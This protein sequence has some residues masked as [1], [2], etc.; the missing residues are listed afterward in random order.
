MNPSHVPAPPLR[1]RWITCA[2]PD[3]TARLRL[4]C[5]PFAGGGAAIWHP[6]AV[7]LAGTAEIVAFRLPGRESRFNEPPYTDSNT[8]VAALVDELAPFTSQPF[9]LCGHSLG[10]LLSFEVARALRRCGLSLPI[11]LIVSGVKAAH[12]PR[13]WPDIH[14]LPADKLLAEVDRRYGGIPKELRDDAELM[15]LLL[16]TL[17]ADLAVYETYSH[18][19]EPPVA[20]PILAL[21]G[22]SDPVVSLPEIHAWSN[23]TT[24]HFESAIFPGGHFFLQERL[25]EATDRVRRFLRQQLP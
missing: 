5:L 2:K 22:A 11:A 6:W 25:V 1:S 21:G 3:P 24:S 17:R 18:V 14:A 7:P 19:P 9:A 20:I 10:G 15:S 13:T 4:W 8:L 16:P 12:L 23:H